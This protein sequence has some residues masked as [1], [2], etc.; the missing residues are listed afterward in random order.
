MS[1]EFL[2][3]NPF[4]YTFLKYFLDSLIPF[5]DLLGLGRYIL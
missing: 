2:T 3:F 4:K 5:R 1:Y